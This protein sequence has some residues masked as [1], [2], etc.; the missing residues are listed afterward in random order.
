M[1]KEI[2]NSRLFRYFECKCFFLFS[3]EF[4][5][6]R[7]QDLSRFRDDA[8]TSP[9]PSENTTISRP[10]II[11]SPRKLETSEAN[12]QDQM[13]TT[14]QIHQFLTADGQQDLSNRNTLIGTSSGTSTPSNCSSRSPSKSVIVRAGS[15]NVSKFLYEIGLLLIFDSLIPS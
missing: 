3:E 4:I 7:P 13:T 2:E 14:N 10:Q 1:I 12:I 15:S 5:S 6:E 9:I 8:F 11:V